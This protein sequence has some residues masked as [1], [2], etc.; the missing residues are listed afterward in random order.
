VRLHLTEG[1]RSDFKGADVLLKDLPK[2]ETL[3]GDRGY[4]GNKIREMLAEQKIATCI[5][6]K[7]SKRNDRILQDHLQDPIQSRKPFC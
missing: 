3:I 2:A 4:D 7:N 1:P 5:P 6:P